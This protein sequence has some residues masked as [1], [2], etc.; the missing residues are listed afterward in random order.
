[1]LYVQLTATRLEKLQLQGGKTEAESNTKAIPRRVNLY[2]HCTWLDIKPLVVAHLIPMRWP[3]SSY[4]DAFSCL[5]Q[6]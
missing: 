3:T 2:T 1:M 6:N 5:D 4:Y